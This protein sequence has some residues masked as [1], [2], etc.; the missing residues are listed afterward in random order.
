MCV[1]HFFPTYPLDTC[2]R[3][4]TEKTAYM[5]EKPFLGNCSENIDKHNVTLLK[6]T[7]DLQPNRWLRQA[8]HCILTITAPLSCLDRWV[9]TST[10][11]EMGDL[12][13]VITYVK[14]LFFCVCFCLCRL[15]APVEVLPEAAAHDKEPRVGIPVSEKEERVSALPGS[16]P[17][18]GVVWERSAQERE[19]QPQEAAGGP[20][21]WGERLEATA[22]LLLPHSLHLRRWLCTVTS[23]TASL[24]RNLWESVISVIRSS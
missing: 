19:W 21:E 11:D 3:G 20:A 22:L 15:L 8:F 12:T 2:F 5:N 16:P 7:Y 13:W 6:A 17:E 10:C 18:S 24:V 9:D 23:A 1:Y 14:M 4:F